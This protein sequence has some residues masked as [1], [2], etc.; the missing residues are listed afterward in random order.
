MAKKI[1]VVT[2]ASAGIG[3]YTALG[4]ARAGMRVI[5]VGHD[6]T[7]TEEARRFIEARVPGAEVETVR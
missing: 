6:P 2:G 1:A 5:A 3:L 4:L 7:R